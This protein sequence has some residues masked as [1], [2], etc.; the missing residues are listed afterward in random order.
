MATH[1]AA[2]WLT[3]GLAWWQV[4]SDEVDHQGA[5]R[6]LALL[7]A[8]ALDAAFSGTTLHL[9]EAQLAVPLPRYEFEA[10]DGGPNRPAHTLWVGLKGL[11]LCEGNASVSKWGSQ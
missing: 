4:P 1:R 8:H 2:A 10:G 6:E 7:G 5:M 11:S 9:P 3:R